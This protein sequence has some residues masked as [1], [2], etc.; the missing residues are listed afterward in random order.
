MWNYD[1]YYSLFRQQIQSA[2]STYREFLEHHKQQ[3]LDNFSTLV[4]SLKNIYVH[5]LN[6]DHCN[7]EKSN[8]DYSKKDCILCFMEL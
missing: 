1:R 5:N 6:K 2:T 4:H 7:Y 3:S 8:I